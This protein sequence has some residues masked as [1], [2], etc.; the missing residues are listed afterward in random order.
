[1]ARRS[2]SRRKKKS[3]APA[4]GTTPKPAQPARK[5]P[6]KPARKAPPR[7]VGIPPIDPTPLRWWLVAALVIGIAVIGVYWNILDNEFV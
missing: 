4:A 6:R 3:V 5:A 2:K 1:M 7:E